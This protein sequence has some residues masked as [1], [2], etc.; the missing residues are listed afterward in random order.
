MDLL[1]HLEVKLCWA[2]LLDCQEFLF[3]FL[4]SS[5]SLA[6]KKGFLFSV[7]NVRILTFS[8]LMTHLVLF[9]TFTASN[10]SLYFPRPSF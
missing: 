8:I 7:E 3:P 4:S 5:F 2:L 10:T 6:E 1:L 9:E